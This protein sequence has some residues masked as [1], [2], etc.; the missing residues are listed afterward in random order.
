MHYRRLLIVAALAALAADGKKDDPSKIDL[1]TMQGDWASVAYVVDGQAL[2]DEDAQSFFRT[3][4][5]DQYAVFHFNKPLGKGTFKIDATK[6]PKTIDAFPANAK[7]KT[8]PILG[9][10]EFE[11]KKYKLCFASPGKPRPTEFA[12]KEDS[13]QTLTVWERET[14]P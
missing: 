4:K 9:I 6:Q 8:K 7:D 1:E 2:S 3:V 14:K 5:G 13:G 10:Y 12:S 11:G